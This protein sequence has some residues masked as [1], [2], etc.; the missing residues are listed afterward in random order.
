MNMSEGAGV[1]RAGLYTAAGPDLT[2]LTLASNRVC[3]D[4]NP[5]SLLRLEQRVNERSGRG[6]LE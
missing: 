1:G 4:N 6:Q 5:G 3:M 2:L